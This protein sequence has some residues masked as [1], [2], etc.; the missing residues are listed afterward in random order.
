M[1]SPAIV[2]LTCRRARTSG[3]I[4]EN[5][6]NFCA[7][8]VRM[9]RDLY[10]RTAAFYLR[11]GNDSPLCAAGHNGDYVQFRIIC[12]QSLQIPCYRLLSGFPRVIRLMNFT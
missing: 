12:S 7:R 2:R 10:L 6:A 11:S 4:P 8:L 5:S 3:A 1:L 9:T